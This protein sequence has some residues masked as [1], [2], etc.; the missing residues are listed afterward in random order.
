MLNHFKRYKFDYNSG[1]WVIW[2]AGR[3]MWHKYNC[4]ISI[5]NTLYKLYFTNLS[6]II[7]H[8]MFDICIVTLLNCN[9]CIWFNSDTTV[10]ITIKQCQFYAYAVNI[11]TKLATRF[12]CFIV[13]KIPYNVCGSTKTSIFYFFQFVCGFTSRLFFLCNVRKQNWTEK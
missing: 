8:V 6:L 12:E 4:I 1:L 5:C 13:N 2:L 10:I 11:A 9:L 3:C 7:I